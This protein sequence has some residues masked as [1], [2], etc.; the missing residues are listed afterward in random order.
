MT[1]WYDY[2]RDE[3]E[4]QSASRTP[5]P[6]RIIVLYERALAQCFLHSDMWH[7]YIAWSKAAD[8]GDG[9]VARLLH[10]YQRSVQNVTLD[11]ALWSG[12]MQTME[13]TGAGESIM[14]AT[15]N[16]AVQVFQSQPH[17]LLIMCVSMLHYLKRRP[18]TPA[19]I[20]KAQP[21]ID[22]AQAAIRYSDPIA[23]ASTAYTELCLDFFSCYYHLLARG[24]AGLEPVRA[25]MERWIAEKSPGARV[26]FDWIR[27]E[28][29]MDQEHYARQLYSRSARRA[30]SQSAVK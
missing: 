23:A 3:Q 2:L 19:S 4:A 13:R 28:L 30:P 25:A 16:R 17:G 9:H 27:L 29:K 21:I 14:W 24:A 18:H 22:R 7:S 5:H 10:V 11:G 15:F 8:R 6:D 12:L 1:A 26:W 20:E